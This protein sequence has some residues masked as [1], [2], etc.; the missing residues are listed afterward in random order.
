MQQV[1]LDAPLKMTRRY[2]RLLDKNDHHWRVVGARMSK[3]R[4]NL[5]EKLNLNSICVR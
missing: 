5:K 1:S 3:E 4:M 2:R